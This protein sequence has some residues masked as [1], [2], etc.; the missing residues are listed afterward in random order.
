[1]DS[2]SR[3]DIDDV[4]T[5]AHDIFIMFDN[6][7]TIANTC[8]TLQISDKHLVISRVESNRRLIEDVDNPLESCAYLRGE[9]YTLTLSS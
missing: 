8:Q 5:L 6:Y 1:M 7:D 2:C 3:A 9:P 4:V